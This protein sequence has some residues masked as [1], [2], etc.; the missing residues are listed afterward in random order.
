M[1][2]VSTGIHPERLPAV[3]KLKIKPDGTLMKILRK[4]TENLKLGD[5]FE[6]YCRKI[7]N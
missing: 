1:K 6:I 2:I 3:K 4:V 5:T 7:K